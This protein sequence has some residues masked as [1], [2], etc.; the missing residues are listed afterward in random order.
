MSKRDASLL[1]QDILDCIKNIEGY[2]EG[3][4]Q[5]AFKKDR[6]TIDA[7]VRNLEIIGE[8]ANTLPTP[9]QESH[10]EIK[11]PQI[12]GLRNRIVHEYFDVDLDIIWFIIE[13]ELAPLKGKI[14]K[15][16]AG[17]VGGDAV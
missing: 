12:I 9:Y 5:E 4:E 3:L 6:K 2:T 1:L 8:A 13:N 17:E 11:W 14:E 7:V 10:G 15:L 16:L